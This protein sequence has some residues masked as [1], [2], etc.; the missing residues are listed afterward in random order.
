MLYLEIYVIYE[1]MYEVLNE[2][3]KYNVGI[4]KVV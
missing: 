4:M 2:K 3:F 1:F